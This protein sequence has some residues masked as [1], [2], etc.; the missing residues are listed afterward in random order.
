[1]SKLHKELD[2]IKRKYKSS[3]SRNSYVDGDDDHFVE[4]EEMQLDLGIMST[5]V[6]KCESENQQLQRDLDGAYLALQ[7]AQV[8]QDISTQESI[9]R[10]VRTADNHQRQNELTDEKERMMQVAVDDLEIRVADLRGEL[11][12]SNMRNSWYEEGQGLTEIVQSQKKLEADLRRRDVDIQ[13]HILDINRKNDQIA[14]LERLS[15]TMKK[16]LKNVGHPIDEKELETLIKAE[17]CGIQFQNQELVKQVEALEE[18]RMD[19]LSRLRKNASVVGEDGM[20]FLGLDPEQLIAVVEFANNLKEEKVILPLDHR[21]LQLHEELKSLKIKRQSDLMTIDRLE[22]EM[23]VLRAAKKEG[24]NNTLGPELK[25]MLES[26]EAQN[27]TL[28]ESLTKSKI[29]SSNTLKC[30]TDHDELALRSK[31]CT[32]LDHDGMYEGT[33]F[34]QQVGSLMEK[35]DKQ[36][37]ELY[38]LKDLMAPQP[39]EIDEDQE[40][41][42]SSGP[43]ISKYQ[44]EIARLKASIVNMKRPQIITNATHPLMKNA[45]VQVGNNCD[46]T[47]KQLSI[48]RLGRELKL[49]RQE[50]TS[51]QCKLTLAESKMSRLQSAATTKHSNRLELAAAAVKELKS[52]LETKNKL[53]AKFRARELQTISSKDQRGDYRT[54]ANMESREMVDKSNDRHQTEI[55]NARAH[56]E[57]ITKQLERTNYLLNESENSLLKT[58]SILQGEQERCRKMKVQ[59]HEMLDV[60]KKLK[61]ESNKLNQDNS[62]LNELGKVWQEHRSNL[63]AT[64]GNLKFQLKEKEERNTTLTSSLTKR[65]SVIHDKN[66]EIAELSKLE[67]EVKRLKSSL[68]VSRSRLRLSRGQ[69][70]KSLAEFHKETGDIKAEATRRQS[71]CSRFRKEIFDLK[72]EKKVIQNRSHKQEIKIQELKVL[73]EESDHGACTRRYKDKENELSMKILA[74]KT[75]NSRLRGLVASYKLKVGI[76]KLTDNLGSS[77]SLKKGGSAK[78]NDHDPMNIEYERKISN[79]SK[80]LELL[81]KEHKSTGSIVVHEK[82]IKELKNENKNLRREVEKVS[83]WRRNKIFHTLLTLR[84]INSV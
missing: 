42:N 82:E 45:Q 55:H 40:T 69:S 41:C 60:I 1:M 29:Q 83:I 62:K 2:A 37:K 71:E 77:K 8:H 70:E 14:L 4:M 31:L 11:N 23:E 12:A 20:A 36:Q 76:N 38:T 44:G 49:S 57:A 13:K 3:T 35:Y 75:D 48:S 74:L 47:S 33:M 26:I 19:L 22:R 28:V 34:Y 24:A 6:Q 10:D 68:D 64:I 53:L 78:T 56:I 80:Q 67:E 15:K 72:E 16:R 73:T 21:S 65:V 9:A 81:S 30:T 17:E 39:N 58:K 52:C 59:Y 51:C 79:L 46:I 63:I 50:L 43:E 84:S 66:E 54:F 61:D 32:I 27:K 25:D 18:E 7:R 5:R